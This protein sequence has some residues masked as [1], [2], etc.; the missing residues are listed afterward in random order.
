MDGDLIHSLSD[1]ADVG[2]REGDAWSQE[3]CRISGTRNGK[4]GGRIL[5]IVPEVH[6]CC[7]EDPFCLKAIGIV[8]LMPS[9]WDL[10]SAAS[11]CHHTGS[12]AAGPAGRS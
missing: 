7:W 3:L 6:R 2:E 5:A 4:G 11:A 9:Y 8:S 12:R 1:L 10:K